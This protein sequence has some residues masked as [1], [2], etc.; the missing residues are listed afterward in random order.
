MLHWLSAIFIVWALVMG[1]YVSFL[2]ETARLREQVAQL[3]VSLATLFIPLFAWRL[4]LRLRAEQAAP[5]TLAE[6]MAH[7]A[8][9]LLY[10]LTALVLVTG[11]LMMNRPIRIFDWL[12]LPQ[13]LHDP[14]LL[15][16]LM[17]VHG[18]SCAVLAGLVGLHVLAVIKHEL[19]GR[20]VLRRM[21]FRISRKL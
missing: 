11:V 8:H 9:W 6:H 7:W 1:S 13:P 20:R 15:K 3:N 21:G 17:Q 10:G 4:W 18:V 12:T 16:G 5:A 2:P 14:A 19:G